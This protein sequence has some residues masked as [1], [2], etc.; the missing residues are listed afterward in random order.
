MRLQ[1]G[2]RSEICFNIV[3]KISSIHT[4][5]YIHKTRVVGYIHTR[6]HTLKLFLE[7][8]EPLSQNTNSDSFHTSK[9]Q[10]KLRIFCCFMLLIPL[11]HS[12][13]EK[14]I[15]RVIG[16]LEELIITFFPRFCFYDQPTLQFFK[17]LINKV[18]NKILISS[19]CFFKCL[20]TSADRKDST[21]RLWILRFSDSKK[22]ENYK[23]ID[24]LQNNFVLKSSF[25]NIIFICLI[26]IYKLAIASAVF[27]IDR[28]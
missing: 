12:K 23:M 13:S 22:E 19:C 15:T 27:R 28:K 9:L 3:S 25:M 16:I 24:F 4:C 7:R 26:I 8:G 6:D 18:E 2:C 10:N 5:I 1:H 20:H 21:G 17:K 14:K 11:D